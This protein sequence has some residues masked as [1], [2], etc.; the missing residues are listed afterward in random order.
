M[1]LLIGT[2]AQGFKVT[3]TDQRKGLVEEMD[4]VMSA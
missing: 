1:Y 4:S 2:I 3:L